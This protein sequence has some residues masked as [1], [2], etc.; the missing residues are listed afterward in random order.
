V[1]FDTKD[2]RIMKDWYETALKEL[3][4]DLYIAAEVTPEQ[5]QR[6]YTAL[7]KM[8]LIDYDLEKEYLYDAYV[9]DNED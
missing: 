8:G 4:F 1:A 9:E 2:I 7:S 5:A 6:V 3:M